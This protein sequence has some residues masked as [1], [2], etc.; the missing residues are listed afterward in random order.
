MTLHLFDVFSMS[1]SDLKP[2]VNTDNENIQYFLYLQKVMDDDIALLSPTLLDYDLIV[3]YIQKYQH[4]LDTINKHHILEEYIHDYMNIQ[5]DVAT[6]PLQSIIEENTANSKDAI[7]FLVEHIKK[8]DDLVNQLSIT[9]DIRSFEMNYYAT[10][11]KSNLCQ[12][13]QKRDTIRSTLEKADWS[14]YK[15]Y[16]GMDVVDFASSDMKEIQEVPFTGIYK[17]VSMIDPNLMEGVRMMSVMSFLL[18]KVYD[19]PMKNLSDLFDQTIHLLTHEIVMN[20]GIQ[21]AIQTMIRGKKATNMLKQLE[22]MHFI[23]PLHKYNDLIIDLFLKTTFASKVNG[24]KYLDS[25]L[26]IFPL[27]MIRNI[28]CL[29]QYDV[30]QLYTTLS[31]LDEISC[32]PK[33]NVVKKKDA[34]VHYLHYFVN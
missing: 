22:E 16:Y 18:D 24:E 33:S 19:I 34:D 8:V 28:V 27:I 26:M 31:K 14:D 21:K 15:T 4:R 12:T 5:V 11:Q 1:T 6:K 29:L 30:S 9:K 10:T 23:Q 25:I 17:V 7:D 13:R 20:G 3:R 2:H 32:R